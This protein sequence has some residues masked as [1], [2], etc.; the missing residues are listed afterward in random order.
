[1]SIGLG[2][3][4]WA[5][6]RDVRTFLVSIVFGVLIDVDHLFDYWF[7]YRTLRVD[8]SAF[9]SGRY[10][11]VSKRIFIL[12]HAFEYLPVVYLVWAALRGRRWAVAATTAMSTHLIADH[13]LNGVRPLAYFITYRA[14]NGFGSGAVINRPARARR[15]AYLRRRTERMA[16]GKATL[17]DRLS[18]PFI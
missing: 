16:A 18:Q 4:F 13:L 14:L 3:L 8:L 9:F 2:T 10:E 11:R 12:L 7:A 17:V 15:R 5:K 1:M 6:S